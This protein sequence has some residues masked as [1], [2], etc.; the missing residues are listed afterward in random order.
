M[1][2]SGGGRAQHAV[3]LDGER[4]AR[5]GETQDADQLLIDVEL[6]A[7][8]AQRARDG[9]EEPLVGGRVPEGGVEDARQEVAAAESAALRG[10]PAPIG[11]CMGREWIRAPVLSIGGAGQYPDWY[12]PQYPSEADAP[13]QTI[14]TTCAALLHSRSRP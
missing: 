1:E 10:C 11:S 14:R 9:E 12:L 7:R 13:L 4:A 8:D 6:A 3:A 2:G 5:V